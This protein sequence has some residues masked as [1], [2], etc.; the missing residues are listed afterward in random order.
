[1][2]LGAN[3]MRR[4]GF[5]AVLSSLAAIVLQM[6]ILSVHG[7]FPEVPSWRNGSNASA[8]FI[9]GDSSVDCGNNTLF[10]PLLHARFSLYPCN[11]SDAT[12]LPQLLAVKM[13]LLSI[14][15]FYGRKGS[16]EEI[17]RGLNFGSTQAKIISQGSW[18]HQS[19][20][21][22]LR[23]V[24]DTLQLLQLQL[25]QEAA[26]QFIKSSIFCLSFGKEDYLDLFLHNSSRKKF[27]SAAQDFATILA[28]QVM[29]ALRF[30]YESN[31]RKIICLGIMP[32]G[33]TPRMVWQWN[34]TSTGVSHGEGCVL[35]VNKQV[36]KFN[37]M[38]EQNIA[39]LNKEF[40]DAQMV[41]CDVYKGMIEI[42]RKPKFY[43]FEDTESACCGLGLN[44][45]TVGCV[46]MDMACE[47]A[48]THIWWDLLNPTLA[49]NS[50]LA[51]AA[52]SGQ[53]F[54]SLCRP[55]T[56]QKLVSSRV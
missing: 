17:L 6:A 29:H 3:I 55:I 19:L 7:Q 51:N 21:N 39:E 15:P 1:M 24:S 31:V 26:L 4:R 43:G 46:S 16:L 27:H 44:G 50:I 40:P 47:Q 2:N 32:L 11:G 49:V 33:Y 20:N 25:P 35:E 48:S 45:A 42:I 10:Y 13:G 5:A 41:F 9:L 14:P 8:M 28:N 34:K 38:L 12:L 52:W 30:L 36:L 23:Q 18:S 56:V 22:Q 54:S 53:P 37:K